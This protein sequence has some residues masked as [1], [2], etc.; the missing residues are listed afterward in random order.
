MINDY[1]VVSSAKII[2]VSVDVSVITL[3]GF[4]ANDIINS[5]ISTISSYFN[6]Q[7]IELGRDINISELKSKIQTLNGV[8]TVVS[9]TFKNEINGNYS[10]GETSMAYSNATDRIIAPIDE[11]LYAQP[12]EIYHIRYPEKDIRVATK[13]N[14]G[15]TIG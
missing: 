13:T 6:P 14:N 11:T 3:P 1:I 4:V 2:D 12:N 10:W 15:A 9:L 8:N 5:V 7:N